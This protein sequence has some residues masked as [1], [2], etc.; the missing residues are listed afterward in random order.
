VGTLKICMKV[1][2]AAARQRNCW[3]YNIKPNSSAS[4]LSFR[5]SFGVDNMVA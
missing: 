3:G 1:S 5:R 4:P 2:V